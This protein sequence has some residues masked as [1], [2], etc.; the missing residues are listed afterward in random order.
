M[1]K[2]AIKYIMKTNPINAYLKKHMC[3]QCGARLVVSYT[4]KIVNSK[5]LEAKNYDFSLGDT[6]LVGDVEFR[7]QCLFCD[8]CHKHFSFKD[9]KQ[10]EKSLKR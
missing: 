7:T 2:N 4:S 10:I 5:S 8:N 3:P 9:I 6:F 1:R